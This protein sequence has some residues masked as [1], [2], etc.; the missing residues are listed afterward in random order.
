[1]R[2]L[3]Y[4]FIALVLQF[5]SIVNQVSAEQFP[6]FDG[7]YYNGLYYPN[8]DILE[9]GE[10]EHL[11]FQIYEKNF[12]IEISG[13]LVEDDG[14][15]I[16]L[17]AIDLPLRGERACR[18][19]LAP[20]SFEIN[21]PVYFYL[22]KSDKEMNNF[23]VTQQ[24]QEEKQ[25]ITPKSWDQCSEVKPLQTARHNDR[26]TKFP[27]RK[28]L[29]KRSETQKNTNNKNPMPNPVNIGSEIRAPASVPQSSATEKDTGAVSAPSEF[30]WFN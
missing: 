7:Q 16:F 12:P 19:V 24:P 2:Y 25:L 4:A 27:V 13:K 3:I 17:F 15:K 18:R 22:D 8:L 9:W 11:E 14:K 10:P 5:T 1:M 29:A 26:T 23:I 6:I 20:A 21:Q 28:V 30:N